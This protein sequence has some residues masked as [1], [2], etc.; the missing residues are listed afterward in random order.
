MA[1]KT[2]RIEFTHAKNPA[3]LLPWPTLRE[4]ASLDMPALA[5][6]LN[7]FAAGLLPGYI[8]VALGETA[9]VKASATATLSGCVAA[10]KITINAVD[11][12]AI[13]SGATGNQFNIAG[14]KAG[15]T[16]LFASVIATDVV[17]VNGV[18]FTCVASGAT[19]DEFNV[20]GTDTDT[21]ANAVIAINASVSAGVANITASASTATLILTADMEGA[22]GNAFTL[23][24]PDTTITVSGATFTGGGVNDTATAAAL[25][26][27]INASATAK[28]AGYVHAS[29]ALGVVTI[30]A[31]INGVIGNSFTLT[32]TGSGITVTGAGYLAGGAGNDVTPVRYSKT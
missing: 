7:A 31:D 13:D 27:A 28:I 20:G 9:A 22:A 5:N 24:T 15:A 23:A 25:A 2:L 4:D 16:A 6:L 29:S 11:F 1:N 12:T 30:E 19:G 8:D 14:T 18:T 3:G 21:V 32:K 10:E 26:A 17:V